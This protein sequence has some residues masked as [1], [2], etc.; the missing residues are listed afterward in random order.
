MNIGPADPFVVEDIGA[1]G[2]HVVGEL[3][4]AAVEEG[5]GRVR[6]T[7]CTEAAVRVVVIRLRSG[8]AVFHG[9]GNDWQRIGKC[10]A[11]D[12]CAENANSGHQMGGN[13]AE[14]CAGRH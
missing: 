9:V 6:I 5:A 11:R 10:G 1:D 13:M 8:L 7:G 2:E 4:K 3:A 14:F 12:Y